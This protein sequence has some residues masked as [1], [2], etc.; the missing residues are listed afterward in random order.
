MPR[1][2]LRPLFEAMLEHTPAPMVDLEAPLQFQAVTLGYDDYVGR[3]VIGR[4]A[5][6]KLVR[7]A[8]VA[9]IGADGELETFRVTKLFGSRGLR[10]VELET[11]GA[12]ELA[13]IA[14][15]DSIEIGD[16]VCDPQAPEALRM[17]YVPSIEDERCAR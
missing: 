16:T 3:L 6:G 10:R 14:G 4:V 2:D 1:R 7:G 11:A 8:T 12:G 15:I 9:R 17:R 13:V 5:R